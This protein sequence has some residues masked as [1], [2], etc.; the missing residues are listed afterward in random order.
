M[1]DTTSIVLLVVTASISFGV[2]RAIMHMRKKK[3]AAKTKLLAER[4]A[5]AARD[6]P[7]SPPS[8][9]K[10][11]RKREQQAQIARSRADK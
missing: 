10:S 5:Q 7:Q 2:G 3:Q 9:N 1:M 11:K 6:A 4:A 8:N